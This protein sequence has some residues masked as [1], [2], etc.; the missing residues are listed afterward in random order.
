MEYYLGTLP[1]RA[2]SPNTN[3]ADIF[4]AGKFDDTDVGLNTNLYDNADT[5][6][7]DIFYRE[8]F[9]ATAANMDTNL[10]RIYFDDAGAKATSNYIEG[11]TVH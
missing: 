8:Q 11:V 3:L 9:M 10:G 6:S 7:D 4:Y 5:N 2:I 1:G